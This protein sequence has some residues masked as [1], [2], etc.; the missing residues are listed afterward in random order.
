MS[1]LT[2]HHLTGDQSTTTRIP[3]KRTYFPYFFTSLHTFLPFFLFLI[4]EIHVPCEK[5]GKN[6][7]IKKKVVQ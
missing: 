5:F 2:G 3:E 4:R 7:S 1:T 6:E